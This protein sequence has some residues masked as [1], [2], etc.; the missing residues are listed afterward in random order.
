MG[1]IR[2]NIGVAALILSVVVVNIALILTGI[3]ESTVTDVITEEE[4]ITISHTTA[5][6]RVPFG[7]G[8]PTSFYGNKTEDSVTTLPPKVSITGSTCA[9]GALLGADRRSVT[10][11]DTAGFVGTAL[12]VS[13]ITDNSSSEDASSL[14]IFELFPFLYVIIFVI[15][16]MAGSVYGGFKGG[17]SSVEALVLQFVTIIVGLILTTILQPSLESARVIFG[18]ATQYDG[19]TAILSLVLLLWIVSLIV[20]MVGTVRTG[21]KQFSDGM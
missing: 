7:S 2:Q 17:D 5:D 18:Y 16:P 19:V 1:R 4:S 13:Y 12:T 14:G 11:A 10:C 9:G 21:Y 3:V 15:L 8:D 6:T 20:S